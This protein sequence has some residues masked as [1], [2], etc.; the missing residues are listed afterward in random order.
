MEFF[1]LRIDRALALKT[2]EKTVYMIRRVGS[3]RSSGENL[4]SERLTSEK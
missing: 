3:R 1:S 4:E 2:S